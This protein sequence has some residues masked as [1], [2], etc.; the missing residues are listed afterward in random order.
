MIKLVVVE[1]D[2]RY[3]DE[4]SKLISVQN[5]LAIMG[6]GK[7]N[8]DAIN[9]VQKI[10]PDIILLDI[11]SEA[12]NGTEISFILKRYSPATSIVIL[13]VCIRDIL[14]HE[15]IKGAITGYLLKD[16]DMNHL[17]GILRGIYKGEPYINS[18]IMARAFKILGDHYRVKNGIHSETN[19]HQNDKP[20][21]FSKNEFRM[22][23]FI[24]EGYSVKEISK[25]LYLKEGTVRNYISS[26]MQKT[27]TKAR[28][29]I[30]LYAQQFGF[31]MDKKGIEWI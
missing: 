25:F 31:G 26:I 20:V 22:L 5:D 30:V 21:H 27:G 3:I 28:T 11:G 24:S 7:D 2:F 23:R 9:L 16:S 10:K 13:D 29:Q 8:Y 18:R 1:D 14:I 17:A 15:M 12:D 19:A 4:I 6:V